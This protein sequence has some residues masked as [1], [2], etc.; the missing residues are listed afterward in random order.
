MKI[1]PA[2]TV[3]TVGTPA[4]ESPKNAAVEAL[5]TASR[6]A[7]MAVHGIGYLP[8]EVS[9]VMILTLLRNI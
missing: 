2:P 5:N 7:L 9:K 4:L 6:D 8:E 1:Q 3:K